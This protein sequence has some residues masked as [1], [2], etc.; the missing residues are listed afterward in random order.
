M[1]RFSISL[2]IPHY[3]HVPILVPF[4]YPYGIFLTESYPSTLHPNVRHLPRPAPLWL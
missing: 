1:L 2:T 3:R 4:R